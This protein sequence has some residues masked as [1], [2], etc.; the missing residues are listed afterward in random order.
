MTDPQRPPGATPR[1]AELLQ[2][3]RPGRGDDR[4]A[5]DDDASPGRSSGDQ[6]DPVARQREQTET[7]L[8]NVR[9]P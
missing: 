9:H 8:D 2:P 5:P 6:E 7:A 1:R 4:L 3:G